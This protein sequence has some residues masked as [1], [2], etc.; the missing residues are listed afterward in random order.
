MNGTTTSD[1]RVEMCVNNSYS[2]ICDSQWDIR[3]ARVAC[4]QLGF[5]DASTFSVTYGHSWALINI[6]LLIDVT[7]LRQSVFGEGSGQILLSQLLCNG[8]EMAL[9]RCPSRAG[10]ECGAAGVRCEGGMQFCLYGVELT[11]DL[12]SLCSFLQ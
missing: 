3:D 7:A 8:G 5:S 2:T 6:F 11:L 9:Q 1:G 4:R 10:S 12:I